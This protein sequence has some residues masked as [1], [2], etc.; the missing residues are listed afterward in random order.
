MFAEARRL[1][2]PLAG[3]RPRAFNHGA[4]P[5]PLNHLPGICSFVAVE[6]KV[7]VE[8]HHEQV[9][10]PS[11]S[12]GMGQLSAKVDRMAAQQEQIVATLARLEAA[13]AKDD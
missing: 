7:K 6:C 5:Q 4:H 2:V 8:A 9:R 12:E 13:I 11:S 1:P 10:E 3:R